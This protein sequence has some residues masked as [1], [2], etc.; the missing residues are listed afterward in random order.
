MAITVHC[1]IVSAEDNIFDGLA[2]MVIAHG[3]QGDLGISPGHAP[4]MSAIT[5][6]PVRVIRLGGQEDV[7]YVSG[8]FIEVQPHCVT[9]LADTVIRAADVDQAA[10]EE[11]KKAAEIQ[12]NNKNAEFD[13][14]KAAAQLAEAVAQLRTIEQFKNRSK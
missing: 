11:A 3:S 8:G 5:P 10:A 12:M 4:L 13:Y 9:V 6:G 1:D 2:E 7:Y 14:S